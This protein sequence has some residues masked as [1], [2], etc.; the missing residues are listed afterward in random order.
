[1]QKKKTKT[2]RP[3]LRISGNALVLTTEGP[4]NLEFGGEKRWSVEKKAVFN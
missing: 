2:A 4:R 3:L 1:M